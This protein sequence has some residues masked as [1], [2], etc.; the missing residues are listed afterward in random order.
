MRTFSPSQR[1]DKLRIRQ[2]ARSNYCHMDGLPAYRQ[3]RNQ[4][5]RRG[6]LVFNSVIC[7]RSRDVPL[8]AEKS[9]QLRLLRE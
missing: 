3:I 7:V 8:G 5:N 2:L 6:H 1:P 9:I 4:Y